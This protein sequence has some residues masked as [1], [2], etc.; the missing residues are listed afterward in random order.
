LFI[1]HIHLHDTLNVDIVILGEIGTSTSNNRKNVTAARKGYCIDMLTPIQDRW[2]IVIL[3]KWNTNIF[4]PDW[5]ARNAF[6]TPE[7]KI[8]YPIEPGIPPRITSL[9]TR[10]TP[11]PNQVIITPTELDEASMKRMES[12][13]CKL[14]DVLPHTP[15]SNTG[16]NFAYRFTD[17]SDTNL[18]DHFPF[19]DDNAFADKGMDLESR[20]FSR[21]LR[22]ENRQLNFKTEIHADEA[23]FFFNFHADTPTAEEAHRSIEGQFIL[24]KGVAENILESVYELRRDE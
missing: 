22:C 3:G 2:N 19:V 4:T 14:L 1:W 13:A 7:M 6:E 10:I 12:I 8:E 5:L 24:L 18:L 20:S 11:A 15:I 16:M 9:T 23:H 21:R 17:V